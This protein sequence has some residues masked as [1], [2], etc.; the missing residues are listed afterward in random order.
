MI[1][2]LIQRYKDI[3]REHGHQDEFYKYQ[4]IQHFKVNWNPDAGDF[5]RMLKNALSKQKNLMYNLADGTIVN[6]AKKYPGQIKQLFYLLFDESIELPERLRKF[7]AETDKLWKTIKPSD[8]GFQDERSASVYLTFMYPEKYTFYKN[9]YYTKLCDILSEKKAKKGHKYQH[10]LELLEEFKQNYVLNDEELWELT[11]AKLPGN[12][13]KDEARNILTQDILWYGLDVYPEPDYWV[14]QCNPDYYDIVNEWQSRKTETW[15]IAAH[16]KEIKTGDK[17]IIWVTGKESGCYGLCT[18]NSDIL[19]DEQGDYVEMTIDENL[20]NSPIHKESLMALPEFTGFK[21][22]NQG[23]NFTATKEQYETII[24]LAGGSKEE[25]EFVSTIRKIGTETEMRFHFEMI[26]LF[27]S[28][29]KLK[30]DDKRLVFSTPKNNQGITVSVNQRYIFKTTKDSFRINLPLNLR[31]EILNSP[32]YISHELFKQLS[33]MATPSIYVYFKKNIEL[34]RSFSDRWLSIIDENLKYGNQSAYLKYDNFLYRKA[35]FDSK[36]RERIFQLAFTGNRL[37]KKEIMRD[38]K[39]E[40]AEWLNNNSPQSYRGYIGKSVEKIAYRLEEIDRFFPDYSLFMVDVTN[41]SQKIQEVKELLNKENRDKNT[42]FTEYDS[43]KGSGMPKAILGDNNYAVFLKTLKTN[44]VSQGIKEVNLLEDNPII[45]WEIS[46]EKKLSLPKNLILYGP[47]GTGKTYNLTNNYINYFTDKADGKSKELFTYEL[48]NELAWW[49]VITICMYELEEVKVNELVEHPLMIEKI[50]QS[51]SNKPRNTIWYWLQNHTKEKCPNVNVAKRSEIQI[52]W[53][54]D[55]SL[56]SIDKE[57]TREVLPDLIE[58]LDHW[59]NYIPEKKEAKRYEMITFHQSYGYEEF[60]EGIRPDFQEEE[61]LKYK[62][63]QGVFLRIAEKAKKD[64]NNSYAIFIDEINRGNVSKIFGELITLIEPDK[65]Q[66]E[67][68]ELE[69]ILP[70]SKTKFSVPPNLY[71]IGTMNTADRSIALI[72][73]ALRR[74]FHFK[75]MMPEA[76]LLSGD[77]DGINLQ[78]LLE[79]INERIEFLLDRDHTIGHSYFMKVK[80]KN[81]V[82]RVFK[83]KVIP[84]LQEYF[85]NDWEKIQLVLGDNKSWNKPDSEKLVRIKKHYSVEEEKKLFGYDVEEYEDEKIYEI[86]PM[87]NKEQFGE[88]SAGAFIHIYQKTE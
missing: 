29:K 21:G 10:Y 26:D 39:F 9:S 79:K 81:D 66:G 54:G 47:P 71:I 49:E 30:N 59:K 27:I 35:A 2:N 38:V 82:C 67:E 4:A 18:I 51:N 62:I 70:Y 20:V 42:E 3:K 41:V 80:S 84:L 85:Y 60:I 37:E 36:Y 86:N 24:K 33:G 8:N 17:V 25:L 53:K 11:N 46:E 5:A 7:D 57:L 1:S 6:L 78:L 19:K 77:I 28:S 45:E 34:I 83:N 15:K 12:A 69:V 68:N 22:G 76:W 40:F 55:N 14:F 50:N 43:K 56:W 87:L 58:K 65:R 88:I 72:D 16:K 52:F 44:S 13:W 63:E 61:E 23:T 74:R 64:K 32:D 31:E 48:V 75:E 73:T